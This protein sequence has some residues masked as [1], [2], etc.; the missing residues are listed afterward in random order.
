VGHLQDGVD[1]DEDGDGSVHLLELGLDLPPRSVILD[2]RQ[3]VDKITLRLRR[4]KQTMCYNCL[5]VK[6][7]LSFSIWLVAR[8]L[9]SSGKTSMNLLT[10]LTI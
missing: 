9:L 3:A 5:L 2:Y 4:Y 10:R 6:H 1:G 7:I 8:Y